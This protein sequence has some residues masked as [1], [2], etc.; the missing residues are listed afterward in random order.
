MTS[1]NLS[2]F[3][4]LIQQWFSEKVGTP[5]DIQTKAWPEI[6]QGRH[7]LVT[8]PTGSGKTLAAF[9][10]GLNQLIVGAWPRGKVRVLYVSPLKALNNDVQHNLLQPLMEL[11]DHFSR[12]EVPFSGINVQTRSGDTP[13]E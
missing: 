3:H 12:A 8:A 9:L 7:V 1:T 2:Y 6:V 11:R 13:G 10:W 5:T 4:P